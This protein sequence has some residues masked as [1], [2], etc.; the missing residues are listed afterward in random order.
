MAKLSI[1]EIYAAARA[2]GFT[3]QQ[4][5]TWTAIAMAESGGQPGALNDKGEHSMG[6]WQ[7]NVARGVRTNRWGDLNDPLVNARAAFDISQ[8]GRDMRPWTTTHEVNKSSA[9][10]YRTYLAQVEQ[11]TGVKG[12]PRGVHGYGSPLP[13][14]L[15]EAPA[16]G[17]DATAG[18]ASAGQTAPAGYDQITTGRPA[19]AAS[20][21]ESDGLTDEFER[22]LGTNP[23][24]ADTDGDGLPDGFEVG[25]AHTDPRSADTDL[26]G[27]SDFAEQALGTKPGALDSDQ[28]GISDRA[29]VGLGTDPLVAD[30]RTGALPPPRDA[31]APVAPPAD[32]PAAPASTP[33]IRAPWRTSSS[34]R[35][36]PRPGTPMSTGPKP[37]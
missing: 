20:D 34:G 17:N 4:A 2:A 18:P 30:A 31:P 25:S 7:I 9:H 37:T 27:L 36:R 24:S 32:A 3:P 15:P 5:T 28:D 6:L 16:V 23:S 13:P 33:P 26:D 22:R 11:V 12:D 10:D 8:H 29:E 35:P 19:S 21:A 14:A 1:G